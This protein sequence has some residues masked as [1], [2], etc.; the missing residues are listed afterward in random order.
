MTKRNP[1]GTF[2]KGTSGNPGGAPI[3]LT[4]FRNEMRGLSATKAAA[5]LDDQLTYKKR[6]SVFRVFKTDPKSGEEVLEEEHVKET[7]G[8][9]KHAMEAAKEC[10][11]RAWGKATEHIEIDP[12]KLSD[13]RLFEEAAEIVKRRYAKMDADSENGLEH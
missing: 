3:A 11:N 5:F 6:R 12:A 10:N 2:P 7:E 13:E 9:G 4:A 8:F 1:D